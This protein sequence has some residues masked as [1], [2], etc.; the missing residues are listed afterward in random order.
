MQL[1]EIKLT[2]LLD[3]L[4][5]VKISDA[6]YF[7]PKYGGYVSNSRLGLLNPRQGGS[8][9]SFFT[10]FKDE[11]FISSLVIGSAVHELV[12]QNESFEL[13]PSLGKPTA[14]MGAMADEL[15][16]V[17]LEHPIRTSD[18]TE[19]SNKINYYKGKLTPDRIK[20]VNEQC[21]PYWKA[22]KQLIS[23]SDKELIYLDDK[24]RDIVYN[25]VEAL[26][27]NPQVQELL[28]PS[29]LIDAPIS[30]N[31]NALLLDVQA[32]CPNGKTF[33][34]HL[35]AKLDNFTID[36]ESDTVVVND[37]KT[38]GKVVSEIDSNISKYH[39]SRELAMYLFLLRLYVIKEYGIENPT[40]KANY[41]V[42]STIPQ[43]YT[44]VRAMTK[45]ECYAGL[46]EFRTLLR[47]VAYQIGYNGYSL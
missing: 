5:L 24:S 13:A 8:P 20:Q 21:I 7:S 44:K 16:P 36:L 29:G 14:K 32:E 39:Y 42:V 11:G 43:Y 35:K 23:N 10:G 4:Q 27:N 2:P 47:Y 25:C 34:I 17:W 9:E 6:E 37:V 28:H 18:I 19:A 31:E 38:I 26:T 12:L 45:K 30:L 15:Y 33:I 3:T 46:H 41:L 22:R 1:S 40:M